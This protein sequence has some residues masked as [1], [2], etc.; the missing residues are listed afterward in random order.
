MAY[1]MPVL[2][3][4]YILEKSQI[5]KSEPTSLH[6]LNYS[7]NSTHSDLILPSRRNRFRSLSVFAF[8]SGGA[9]G[10]MKPVTVNSCRRM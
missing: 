2:G 6:I 7:S 4:V 1:S 5:A 3:K 9:L 10:L 8:T